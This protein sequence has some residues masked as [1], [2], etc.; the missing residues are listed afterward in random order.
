[1]EI[2]ITGLNVQLRAI[3]GAV[4]IAY[5][6]RQIAAVDVSAHKIVCKNIREAR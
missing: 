5:R 3:G 4:T 2:F 1:M 6:P